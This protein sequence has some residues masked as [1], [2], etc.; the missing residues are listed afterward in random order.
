MA[1]NC[2]YDSACVC[3]FL[4]LCRHKQLYLITSGLTVAGILSEISG[5]LFVSEE[6]PGTSVYWKTV[7]PHPW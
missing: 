5:G 2:S 3:V 4:A 6:Q 7:L 1:R